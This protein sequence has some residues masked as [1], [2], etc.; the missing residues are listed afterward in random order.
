[1]PLPIAPRPTNATVWGISPSRLA[2]SADLDP[3]QAVVLAFVRF[4]VQEAANRAR[5]D[6]QG[7]AAA[8]DHMR[9]AD[10]LARRV[11][12]RAARVTWP[13]GD[14]QSQHVL[15]GAGENTKAWRVTFAHRVADRYDEV[16]NTQAVGVAD[17]SRQRRQVAF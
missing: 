11:H 12:Q 1:M 4:P 16:A 3:V 15:W 9:D 5:G 13:Q 10:D 2:G 7:Q 6:R 17:A 14:G 8:R